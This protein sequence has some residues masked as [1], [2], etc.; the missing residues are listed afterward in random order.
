[1]AVKAICR[2]LGEMAN[3][4]SNEEKFAFGGARTV[5]RSKGARVGLVRDEEY[6]QTEQ[7]DGEQAGH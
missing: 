3:S 4:F 6:A 1:M 2:P 7:A 5:S